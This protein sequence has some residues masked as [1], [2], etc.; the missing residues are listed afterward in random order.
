M[1]E[2]EKWLKKA[3]NDLLAIENN[4]K[5][6]QV[7]YDVCCFHAQQAVEK[8]LKGYLVSRNIS[9][10]KTHDLEFLTRKAME[11]YQPFETILPL[12]RKLIDYAVFPRYPDMLDDLTEED[13]KLAYNNAILIRDFILKHFLDR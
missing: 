10:P 8:L 4:L 6:E 5:A 12:V 7:P 3:G 1:N 11:V 2:H 13:A 9:F